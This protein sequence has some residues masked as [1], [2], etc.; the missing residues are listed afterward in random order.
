MR[1][2]RIRTTPGGQGF[3]F[4]MQAEK[5]RP[6]QF[7]SSV[8]PGSCAEKAGVK[9]GDRIV[10]VNGL[11]IEQDS[12]KQVVEKIKAVPNET[13][14]LLVDREADRYFSEKGTVLSSSLAGV[15]KL[16]NNV[17]KN[18]TN[19]KNEKRNLKSSS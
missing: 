11:N 7:I 15:V 17:G 9:A 4:N 18:I 10:E 19:M 5:G 12:H 6:G 14:L 13:T 8:D 16:E 2:C 1:L 3:G